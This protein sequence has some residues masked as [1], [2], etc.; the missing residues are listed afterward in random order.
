M[1]VEDLPVQS[2]EVLLQVSGTV[3]VRVDT[4]VVD[5]NDSPNTRIG[6]GFIA[7]GRRMIAFAERGS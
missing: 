6:E 7:L 3:A 5:T 4:I 1:N 2:V